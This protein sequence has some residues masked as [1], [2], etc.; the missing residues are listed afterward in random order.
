VDGVS[1]PFRWEISSNGQPSASMV[2]SS[3]EFNPAVDATMFEK[4]ATK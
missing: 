4:P 1:L 3:Y 2:V